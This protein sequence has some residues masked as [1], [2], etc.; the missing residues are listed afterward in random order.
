MCM[1]VRASRLLLAG[2]RGSSDSDRS[3]R[4]L[5]SSA[6]VEKVV[7]R[8]LAAYCLI[9]GGLA[10][11]DAFV[12]QPLMNQVWA[13]IA[14]VALFGSLAATVVTG[15]LE[16]HPRVAAAS[17]SVVYLAILVTWQL[18]A[19]DPSVVASGAPWPSPL[20]TIAFAAA[21]FAF[22]QAGA[23]VYMGSVY[24]V[25]IIVRQTPAG[26]GAPLLQSLAEA[27]YGV[28]IGLVVLL[29]ITMFRRA[30]ASVDSA[31]GAATGR[32]A[33]TVRDHRTEMERIQ[34]DSILH[35]S[36]LT[37]FLTAA[38][39][40]TPEERVL[41]VAMA[42]HALAEVASAG[43]MPETLDDLVPLNGLRRRFTET[44]AELG[45]RATFT[46]EGLQNYSV[47]GS[48]VEALFSAVMQALTNSIQHAGPGDVKRHVH[49]RW[50]HAVL[51][52]T[53]TDDGVGFDVD[54]MTP[55]RLGVR[56]SIIERVHNVGGHAEIASQPGHGTTVT[57]TWPRAE[58]D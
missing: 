19:S 49:I 4:Y 32:Y 30:A 26:G 13:W 53:T 56:V 38:R 1:R 44:C 46:A 40:H 17:F 43:P 45:I 34:V 7:G 55:N 25:Y 42:K 12:G 27:G 35:D 28:I 37:T 47:P 48:V 10:I 18:A 52:V 11:P 24:V 54:H 51:T 29:L 5:I 21:S 16:W 22:R 39:S 33:K 2:V 15:V 23:L 58:G 36:V 50:S 6:L 8:C 20:S 9:F 14:G 41:A 57:M 3:T 31:H